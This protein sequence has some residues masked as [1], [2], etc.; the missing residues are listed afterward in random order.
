[1]FIFITVGPLFYNVVAPS[2][3]EMCKKKGCY[4]ILEYSEHGN[5]ETFYQSLVQLMSCGSNYSLYSDRLCNR[6]VVIN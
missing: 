6:L 2:E 4:I 1:M 3:E 5:Y